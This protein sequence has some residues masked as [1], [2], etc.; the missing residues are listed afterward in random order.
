MAF[1]GRCKPFSNRRN[2]STFPA[3]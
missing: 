1:N 2:Q 3:E